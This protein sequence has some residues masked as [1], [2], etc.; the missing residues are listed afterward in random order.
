MYTGVTI[1]HDKRL[2]A[3]RLREVVAHGESR[4]KVVNMKASLSK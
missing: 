3:F 1:G 4:V 2:N